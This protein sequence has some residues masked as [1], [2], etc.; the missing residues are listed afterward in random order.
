MGLDTIDLEILQLSSKKDYGIMSLA[1]AMSMAH[2]PFLEHVKKLEKKGLITR[3][4]QTIKPRGWHTVIKPTNKIVNLFLEKNPKFIPI[5]SALENM[6]K[7]DLDI[8]EK[9]FKKLKRNIIEK[10]SKK[11]NL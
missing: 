11:H 9:T 5:F 6:N 7:E 2:R 8:F 1:K 3:K 4:I 10:T